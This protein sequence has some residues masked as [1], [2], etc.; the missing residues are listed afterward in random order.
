MF[1]TLQND[2]DF[3]RVFKHGL[4]S[5]SDGVTVY[6][7]HQG[8]GMNRYGI[9]VTSKVGKAVVR[10]R[11]KR[12]VRELI[13]QWDPLLHQGYDLV[14]VANRQE[15]A[16]SYEDLSRHLART[17]KESELAEGELDA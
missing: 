12:R 5:R 7:D 14:I 13:R 15:A 4:S 3:K 1:T 6:S 16:Q 11:V 8:G 10:N 17:L 9:V 2:T